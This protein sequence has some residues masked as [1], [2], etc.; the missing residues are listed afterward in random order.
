MKY[1]VKTRHGWGWSVP[2]APE[3]PAFGSQADARR[4]AEL[5]TAGVP[6]LKAWDLVEAERFAREDDDPLRWRAAR[7]GDDLDGAG[8]ET[9]HAV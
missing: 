3:C 4:Y 9:S 7:D 1:T 5:R 8:K 6:H 2:Q